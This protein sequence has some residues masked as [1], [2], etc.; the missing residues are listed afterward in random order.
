MNGEGEN[1]QR[2]TL[3]VQRSTGRA[4]AALRLATESLLAELMA[5]GHWE[6]ELSSSALSTATAVVALVKVG[7]AADRSEERRVGKECA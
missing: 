1:A 2:S 7:S 4:R 6:G 3:N 5:A